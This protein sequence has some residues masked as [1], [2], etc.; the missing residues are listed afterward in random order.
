MGNY[1]R[2]INR[3]TRRSLD[4]SSCADARGEAPK[5]NEGI[6]RFHVWVKLQVACRE[7]GEVAVDLK[8]SCT[9]LSTFYPGNYG[10][11]LY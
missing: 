6:H 4:Y 11:T 8:K 1:S 9:I 7:G 5:E 2:L 3:D 10:V